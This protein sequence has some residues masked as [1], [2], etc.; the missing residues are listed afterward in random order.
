MRPKRESAAQPRPEPLAVG[1]A[2]VMAAPESVERD[3]MVAEAAYFRAERRGFS[4]DD[5][6]RQQDWLEAEAE[7][8]RL[9]VGVT[10]SDND[11]K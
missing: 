7:V 1:S 2:P 3:R 11:R 5:A 9:I 6:Q 10:R 8:E 4:G